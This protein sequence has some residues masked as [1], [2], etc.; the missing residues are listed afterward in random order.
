LF[1]CCRVPRLQD[2][3]ER[4]D[5]CFSYYEPQVGR[6]LYTLPRQ[7]YARVLPH[8]PPAA[9]GYD[10]VLVGAIGHNTRSILPDTRIVPGVTP[11]KAAAVVRQETEWSEIYVQKVKG[12][13]EARGY[14]TRVRKERDPDTDFTF[15]ARA[16]TF[17]QGGGGYSG[18]VA[19]LVSAS[20]MRV[21]RGAHICDPR[22]WHVCA[23]KAP[24]A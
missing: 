19:R 13:F 1:R 12:F 11:S 2:C 10:V 3:W 16:H 4:A 8:M 23:G 14:T 5:D 24:A 21:L 6:L 9:D 18:L 15:L 22:T 17:V 7:Y 20:G